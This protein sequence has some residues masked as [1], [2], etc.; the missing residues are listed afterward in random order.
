MATAPS[1]LRDASRPNMSTAEWQTRL[2]LA[3]AHRYAAIK[4]WGQLIFNHFTMRVPG[5]PNHFLIK[6]HDLLFEE[7]TASSLLKLDLDGKPVG[8]DENVNAAGFTIHTAVLEARPDVNAVCHIHTIAGATLA[9][10]KDGLRFYTQESTMFYNRIS[11]H[12]SEGVAEDVDERTR[13]ARDLGPT[14]KAMILRNHGLLTCGETMVDALY[15]LNELVFAAEVQMHVMASGADAQEMPAD[16]A[17]KGAQ[18]FEKFYSRHKYAD[19]WPAML[20][21][22]EK[23]HSSYRD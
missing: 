1:Y 20:R 10:M 12:N 8:N 2:D 14:N 21:M 16:V 15:K 19:R 18:Q 22:V 6:P 11:Y 9:A 17:E 23:D 3:A 13:L 4:G 7:V 5:E